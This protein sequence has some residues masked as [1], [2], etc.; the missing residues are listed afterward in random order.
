ME[1]FEN[2]ALFKKYDVYADDYTD[3]P[4][5]SHWS[6]S[7]GDE[8]Y[9]DALKQ[10][11]LRNTDPT[12]LYVHIPFCMKPCYYCI[13]HKRIVHS[14]EPVKEY[15]YKH[16]AKELMLFHAFFETNNLR[17]NIREVFL[18]GGSP[19]LLQ[20]RE[21]DNL[22]YLIGLLCEDIKKLDR[23][24]VEIDPRTCTPDKLF[25]YSRAGVNNLSIGIQ[26][27]DPL[28]QKAVNRVQPLKLVERL[29]T[30]ELR[31]HFFSINFDFLVGLPKQTEKSMTKTMEKAL[32]LSPDRVSFCFFHYTADAFHPHMKACEPWL[33]SFYER[34]KIFAAGLKV[35]DDKGYIRTGFE[36]FAKPDDVVADGMRDRKATY[37]SLGA[38]NHAT[39]VIAVGESGHSILGDAYLVQNFY[40]PE[41]YA[42]AL[43]KGKF[44][45]Y[46]GKQLTIDDAWRRYIIRALRT[47]FMYDFRVGDDVIRPDENK[48]WRDYFKREIEMLHPFIDD[49]L[50][51]LTDSKLLITEDGKYFT[52]LIIS[53]F[54]K[55]LTTP[56]TKQL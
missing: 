50:V 24:C 42:G 34:K 53:V 26:D 44:P 49:G 55:Y 37:T 23:F 15:L 40:E 51:M 22:V 33:R 6:K 4:H 32:A 10:F 8:G 43:D 35:L 52:D 48:F 54:D 38:I 29:M 3:Y 39:N 2:K 41:L 45:V 1:L 19:T 17:P 5:K 7:F 25:Y 27:I 30:P 12:L 47:Y 16:L 11:F 31:K 18:G 9:R 56:R 21:F 13:C 20:E 28:V 36:H 46:R 14:Y